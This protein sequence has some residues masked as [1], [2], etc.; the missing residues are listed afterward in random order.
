MPL[1]A[2][3]EVILTPV[4][5]AVAHVLGYLTGCVVVPIFSLG[6]IRVEPIPDKNPKAIFKSPGASPFAE[7]PRTISADSAICF[8]L[9]FWVVVG[10]AVYFMK[11][12]A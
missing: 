10:V 7:D 12:Q 8:G 1:G 5:E 2:I 3:A 4:F 11:H 6:M 9:L